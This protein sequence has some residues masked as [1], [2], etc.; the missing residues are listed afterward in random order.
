MD[1][2]AQ[3]SGSDLFL[4]AFEP[5][6]IVASKVAALVKQR[7]RLSVSQGLDRGLEQGT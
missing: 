1:I 6:L 5:V 3:D 2:A 4:H 7:L